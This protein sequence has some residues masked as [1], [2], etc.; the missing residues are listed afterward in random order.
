M[1]IEPNQK[2]LT[3]SF[4]TVITFAICL[5][6]VVIVQKF[7]VISGVLSSFANVIAPVTWGIVIAAIPPWNRSFPNSGS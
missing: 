7:S 4:Y 6:L 3:V 2:Y 1:K 5:L